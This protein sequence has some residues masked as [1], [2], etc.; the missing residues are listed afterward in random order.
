MTQRLYIGS[1]VFNTRRPASGFTPGGYD[2]NIDLAAWIN[3]AIQDGLITA[4]GGGGSQTLSLVGTTLSISG[5]NSVSLA[6]LNDTT[7]YEANG[8]VATRT[9]TVT[10]VLQFSGEIDNSLECYIAVEASTSELRLS[11]NTGGYTFTIG[12]SGAVFEDATVTPSGIQY[13]DD[14]SST[15]SINSLVTKLYVDNELQS[16]SAIPTIVETSNSV[17]VGTIIGAHKIILA[18][19]VSNNISV[20]LGDPDTNIGKLVTVKYVSKTAAYVVNFLLNGYDIDG[21]SSYSLTTEKSSVTLLSYGSA[22]HIIS[23]V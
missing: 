21:N 14:Y 19:T 18:S 15:F 1:W 12:Q 22:W 6:S 7:F 8:T 5:G 13:S 3:E 11:A 20:T 4:G 17:S 10:D 2:N 23:Q 9:V 16:I